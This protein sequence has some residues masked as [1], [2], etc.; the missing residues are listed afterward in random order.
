MLCTSLPY[1]PL[2]SSH[3]CLLRETDSPLI[4]LLD[5]ILRS[6]TSITELRLQTSDFTA[7]DFQELVD[8]LKC[9]ATITKLVLQH[10]RCDISDGFGQALVDL[11]RQVDDAGHR[12]HASVI[13]S[14]VLKRMKGSAADTTNEHDFPSEAFCTALKNNETLTSID[15]GEYFRG[16]SFVELLDATEQNPLIVSVEYNA[17]IREDDEGA[18]ETIQRILKAR[19]RVSLAF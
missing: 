5:N 18:S 2:K 12:R 6:N 1:F 16:G 4:E 10:G 15:M 13:E 7:D 17:D 3:S 9:N 8:A 14:V 11:L 19:R